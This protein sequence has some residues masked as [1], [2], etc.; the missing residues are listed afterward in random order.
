MVDVWAQQK[1]Y[2][3]GANVGDVMQNQNYNETLGRLKRFGDKV[4][5]IRDFTSNAV[6]KIPDASLV[7]CV[8]HDSNVYYPSGLS[9]C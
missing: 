6:S 2:K 5:V 1:N 9:L 7:R 3:D 4:S 8:F